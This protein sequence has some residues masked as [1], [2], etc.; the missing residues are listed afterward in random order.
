MNEPYAAVC[1]TYT[2]QQIG[3]VYLQQPFVNE[4]KLSNYTR[5]ISY[6][7]E[8]H[9]ASH[10][11]SHSSGSSECSP[12][13]DDDPAERWPWINHIQE[14]GDVF[15]VETYFDDEV[16]NS[17]D[18][19]AEAKATSLN[20]SGKG[21]QGKLKNAINRS[22]KSIRK[23]NKLTTKQMALIHDNTS[24]AINNDLNHIQGRSPL[25]AGTH[26]DSFEG[27]LACKN[28][29]VQLS[30]RIDELYLSL[31]N[32]LGIIS[33]L[34]LDPVV[35]SFGTRLLANGYDVGKL[36]AKS[37]IIQGIIP[38]S[39]CGLA[40]EIC[41]G[42][43]LVAVNGNEVNQQNLNDMLKQ[44]NGSPEVILTVERLLPDFSYSQSHLVKL[45]TATEEDMDWKSL[46]AYS[47]FCAVMLLTLNVNEDDPEGDIL[48][49]YPDTEVPSKIRNIRGMFLT[50]GD[51]MKNV[52]SGKAESSSLM[53][54]GSLLHAFYQTLDNNLFMIVGPA[55]KISL[56]QLSNNAVELRR[57]LCLL[58]NDET[59][60]FS[61]ESL[62]STKHLISLFMEQLI[63]AL[64]C[65]TLSENQVP[66]VMQY[67]PGMR[68]VMLPASNYVQISNALSDGEA[69]DYGECADD[70]FPH[71]RLYATLGTC[72]FY[73]D[74]LVCSHFCDDDLKDIFVF[75]KHHCL[76][77]LTK[78]EKLHDLVLWK[79]I[80]LTR[81]RDADNEEDYAEPFGTRWFILVVGKRHSLLCTL[82]E[83]GGAASMPEGNPGAHPYYVD[84]ACSILTYLH[85]NAKLESMCE[86]RLLGPSTPALVKPVEVINPKVSSQSP[87]A[88][89]LTK[90]RLPVHLE[91]DLDISNEL[92]FDYNQDYSEASNIGSVSN[93]GSPYIYNKRNSYG[94]ELPF[95]SNDT[96]HDRR[97]S[98]DTSS[99]YSGTL[100]NSS[101]AI[102]TSRSTGSF[103]RGSLPGQVSI[104]QKISL[105]SAVSTKLTMG[106]QNTLFY[107]ATYQQCK[108]IVVCPNETDMGDKLNKDVIKCFHTACEDIHELFMKNE[109]L[110]EMDRVLE[111]GLLFNI[112]PSDTRKSALILKFWVIGRL[113][114]RG[115]DSPEEVYVCFHESIPQS[116]IEMAFKLSLG[117]Y[118]S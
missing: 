54:D 26:S 103:G 50:V 67:L 49:W 100:Q 13:D 12:A 20:Q 57:L 37:I 38:N 87:R 39:P 23:K 60:I 101:G 47:E 19:S 114:D 107:Y 46:K 4:D 98:S 86:K 90:R 116:A 41:I 82:L 17:Q 85:D 21:I 88:I 71:R 81:K 115:T 69:A 29:P 56:Q 5:D 118:N 111:Q 1:H 97:D 74:C 3:D 6:I 18:L 51:L 95:Y 11:Y 7:D 106:V 117:T 16:D 52:T 63:S 53:I 75:C 32:I 68:Q 45:I 2:N 76:F 80:F 48:F 70:F 72:L 8:K 10:Y 79:E 44:I 113:I 104:D 15:F 96:S 94:S 24:K 55:D 43:V 110:E 40:E 73:K 78:E 28:V 30:Q 22:R 59:S 77:F 112:R 31:E 99:S 61:A 92:S 14:N 93:P 64:P 9:A 108:R 34:D 65:Q 91:Q 83:A 102:S 42:D 105:T 36:N 66:A 89:E 84:T 58:N 33:G 35:D 27:R 62:Y 109:F 25:I